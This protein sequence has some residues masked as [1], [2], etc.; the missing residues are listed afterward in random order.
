MCFELA[1]SNANWGQRYESLKRPNETLGTEAPQCKSFKVWVTVLS[2][3]TQTEGKLG[4]RFFSAKGI[5]VLMNVILSQ[6]TL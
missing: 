2:Q 1:P 4:E 5:I 3:W 6:W